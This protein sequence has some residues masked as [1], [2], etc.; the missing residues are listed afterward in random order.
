MLFAKP[1]ASSIS[2][3]AAATAHLP[4]RCLRPQEAASRVRIYPSLWWS[5]SGTSRV[6][7]NNRCTE[8]AL[9]SASTAA[10]SVRFRTSYRSSCPAALQ[11]GV[12]SR[13]EWVV[14]GGARTVMLGKGGKRSYRYEDVRGC[15]SQYCNSNS[16]QRS[17]QALVREW[18]DCATVFESHIVEWSILKWHWISSC[19]F[20]LPSQSYAYHLSTLTSLSSKPP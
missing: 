1:P 15:R 16:F 4:L 10:T 17:S 9:R 6:P 19:A 13:G 11:T 8:G 3:A 18:S 20:G 2:T 7:R 14:P 5:L 12:V